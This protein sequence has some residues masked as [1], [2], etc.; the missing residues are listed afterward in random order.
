MHQQLPQ[1]SSRYLGCRT[2][3][4]A[5]W[6]NGIHPLIMR[7]FTALDVSPQVRGRLSDLARELQPLAR[8]RWSPEANLHITTK[9]IGEWPAERLN[10]VRD[11]L[12]AMYPEPNVTVSGVGFFP[13][14]RRPKVLFAR[15]E[16]S[17]ELTA[18]AQSTDAALQILGIAP[19]KH[20]Y[21]PH[22]TLARI[23]EATR[24]HGL[25]E[26]LAELQPECFG[27]FPGTEYSFYESCAGRYTKLQTYSLSVLAR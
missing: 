8:L 7:L 27:T 4:K 10:E 9:F 12:P 2:R 14:D 19:E 23:P 22:V 20:P 1:Q 6:E 24:L 25:R 26:R 11:A 17:A 5:S 13:N 21:R 3:V 16:P 15:V 18:L